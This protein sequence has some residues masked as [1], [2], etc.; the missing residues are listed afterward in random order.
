VLFWES[1]WFSIHPAGK[2]NSECGFTPQCK[3]L[4]KL[5]VRYEDKLV[6]LWFPFDQFLGQELVT[7]AAT[8]SL[9]TYEFHV[10]FPMTTM[11]EIEGD[12][13]HPICKWLIHK[14]MNG[15]GNYKVFL[16]FNKF[17]QNLL[18]IPRINLE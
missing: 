14:D 18:I 15:K 6:L 10:T 11:P 17:L 3:A 8:K 12:N 1:T 9:F 4:Q 16:N 2:L 5:S 13:Q 7:E